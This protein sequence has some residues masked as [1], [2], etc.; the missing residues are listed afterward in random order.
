MALLST[1]VE[2]AEKRLADID[3]RIAA[4]EAQRSPE[5]DFDRN[6]ALG[7]EVEKL[8]RMRKDA[9][10]ALTYAREQEAKAAAEVARSK[11]VAKVEA[12]RREAER[13]APSRVSKIAKLQD[14]LA[15]EL[16]WLKDHVERADAMNKLAHELGLP[17]ILDGEM[18]CRGTRTRIEPAVFEEREIVRTEEG[19]VVHKYWEANGSLHSHYGQCTKRRER[20]EVRGETV[21]PGGLPKHTSLCSG[22]QLMDV[23]TGNQLWPR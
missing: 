13:D 23:K 1:P 21:I 12:Y 16:A 2:K 9:T 3:A 6:F 4:T 17:F 22:I 19:R 11:K 10:D 14:A 15:P 5:L 8:R 18:L 20:V 7:E